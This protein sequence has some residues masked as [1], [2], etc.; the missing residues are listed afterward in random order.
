N[1][2][3][4]SQY[5]GQAPKANL[6][7]LQF[8]QPDSYLQQSAARNKALISN[9]SWVYGT[10][11]YDLAAA[12]Y[13]AAVRDSLPQV[14]G[15]QS[16]VYVFPAGNNGGVN[17]FDKGANNGG[18]GGT[19]GTIASPGTAKNVITVGAVEQFRNITNSTFDCSVTPCMT[20]Q[21]WVSTSD[22]SNQVVGFSS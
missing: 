13:D 3:T 6:F 9:N 7:A 8:T 2:G 14:S 19:A 4:N 1:P 20:N 21:P 11:T 5:R 10:R 18:S 16:L 17:V 12:S 22:S 15:S